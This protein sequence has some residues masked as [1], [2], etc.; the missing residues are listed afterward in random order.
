MSIESIAS[1]SSGMYSAA[2]VEASAGKDNAA[3]DKQAFLR[4]LIT[5]LSNQDPSSPMDTDSLMTQTT[6]MAS[7]EALTELS[8]TQRESFA[9]QMR[10]NAAGLVGREVSYTG[11][12][13]AAATGTATSVTF[14]GPVPT[15]TV[16]GVEVALDAVS[17]ITARTTPAT[18]TATPVSAAPA[19]VPATPAAAPASSTTVPPTPAAA[20]TSGTVP[21][22][23]A[24]APT[25]PAGAPA[26]PAPA[27]Q[28]PAAAPTSPAP[29]PVPGPASPTPVPAPATPVPAPTTPVPAPT[30]P[31]TADEAPGTA[32]EPPTTTDGAATTTTPPSTTP[33][34]VPAPA[35][36]TV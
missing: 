13:G 28:N 8:T 14:A 9:L 26:A 5:Q 11:A 10:A 2:A 33:V 23:P 16:N 27:P 24:A 20:P 3:L 18:A 17:S 30:T 6:Q 22:T 36:I 25:S 35:T 1:A 15:V 31:G 29:S 32:D 7:M 21:S 34:T 12:D 19:A 4:L